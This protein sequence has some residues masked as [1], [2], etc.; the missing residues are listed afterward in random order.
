LRELER[1]GAFVVALDARRSWFR[2]HRL[3]IWQGE[4]EEA[5]RWLMEGEYALRSEVEPATGM[6]FHLVRGF[7][8]IARG[9]AGVALA[10]LRAAGRLPGGLLTAAHPLT[11]APV[12]QARRPPPP[13]GHRPGP[14]P[15]PARAHPAKGLRRNR[16]GE[17][18]GNIRC[19]SHCRRPCSHCI[20]GIH[21]SA[22]TNLVYPVFPV[23]K[24][25][26]CW[27]LF[28]GPRRAA[29]SLRL[30]GYRLPAS[31]ND[32][33]KPAAGDKGMLAVMSDTGQMTDPRSSRSGPTERPYRLERSEGG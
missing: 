1:A 29:F 13:G 18:N 17:N 23:V 24:A 12:R 5:E 7:L 10:A 31:W 27:R 32:E 20:S 22:Y 16:G 33:T 8:E 25:N 2:Y 26:I 28:R 3:L 6:L 30:A 19:D 11:A 21:H 15:W 9:R 14:C 4:L